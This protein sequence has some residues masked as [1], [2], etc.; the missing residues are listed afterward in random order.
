MRMLQGR[1]SSPASREE[2]PVASRGLGETP[3][4]G[5]SILRAFSPHACRALRAATAG[6]LAILMCAAAVASVVSAEGGEAAQDPVR[7]V[8][9][10]TTLTALESRGFAFATLLGAPRAATLA[11]VRLA[12]PIYADLARWIG[13]DV[14][15]LRAEMAANRRPLHEVTDDNVGRIMDLRWLASP[16]ASFRLIGVVNRTDRRDFTVLTDQPSCGEVRLIYRLAYRFQRG[17]TTYASRLPVNI[18]AVFDAPRGPDGACPD[19]ARIWT[20][21]PGLSVSGDMTE[22]LAAGPLRGLFLRQIEVNAQVVRLPSGMET[23]LGGQAIYLMRVFRIEGDHLVPKPLE[24]TP[25]VARLSK[26]AVLKARLVDY[27][28]SHLPEIDRGVYQLPDAFLAE[29]AL[30]FSTFGSARTANHPF[31]SLFTPSDFSGLAYNQLSYVASPAGLIARLD[32]NTCTGCHQGAA[33]AGFHLIGFDEPGTSPFNV[34]KVPVSP[35]LHA[36]DARR[37]A[38]LSALAEGRAPETFRPLSMAP[39]ADWSRPGTPAAG[40]AAATMACLLPQDEPAFRKGWRC[41]DGLACEAIAHNPHLPVGTGQCMPKR[42]AGLVSGMACLSG[43][44]VPGAAPYLD[45]FRIVRQINS[46]SPAASPSSYTCRPAKLG[47]PGGSAY[48]QC[49]EA[50]RAFAGKGASGDQRPPEIC[51][52]VGGKAF[53]LCV[54]TDNFA[55]CMSASVARGNRPACGEGRFCREDFMCQALPS[56]LAGAAA[57][58][59]DTGYCSPTYFVFQMRI[60]GHPDPERGVP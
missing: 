52:F 60:D 46:P 36:D 37:R 16:L 31:A 27:V 2:E 59:R 14:K 11:E 1:R 57:V 34:V 18:N 6:G 49:T 23:E 20:P 45:R 38:Y 42:A 47:V 54:A 56:N 26:D 12:S 8:L 7:M 40:A 51:A 29:K 24:N 5:R 58:A 9:D 22:W 41:G 25:D 44:V 13:D 19:L 28:R 3:I 33:T 39:P 32:D 10:R 21:P 4:V 53:D 35:H 43:E 48:R 15:A 55:K 17:A 30:S 50:E